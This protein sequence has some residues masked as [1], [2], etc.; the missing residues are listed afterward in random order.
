VAAAVLIGAVGLA[1]RADAGA[2][3]YALDDITGITLTPGRAG[4]LTFGAS[5]SSSLTL[6]DLT[7]VAGTVSDTKPLDAVLA[8]QGPGCAA[9]M[10]N[11]FREHGPHLAQSDALIAMN[12]AGAKND[13][14]VNL[15]NTD[16]GEA[17]STNAIERSF[18]INGLDTITVSFTADP[19]L[20]AT[21]HKNAGPG[22]SAEATIAVSI[23]IRDSLGTGVFLWEPDGAAGGIMGGNELADPF[24]LNRTITADATAD[25]AAA[26][27]QARTIQ[28]GQ[29]G[30]NTTFRMILTME[31]RAAAKDF[32][33]PAPPSLLG[34]IAGLGALVLARRRR[35]RARASG[36]APRCASA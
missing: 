25:P 23:T 20:K 5:A 3:A 21:L 16:E 9:L 11:D 31:E 14:L 19:L 29:I 36:P 32:K 27:F 17:L 15:S 12:L 2:I 35:A 28:L 26:A 33:V 30:A 1:G 8:C 6:A 4:N 24:S 10:Q 18:T 34:V 13:A 22:S 7:S